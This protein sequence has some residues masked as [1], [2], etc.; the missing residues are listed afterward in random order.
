[1]THARLTPKEQEKVRVLTAVIARTI[2]N[3]H[4]AKQLGLSVRQVQRAKAR[5]RREGAESVVHKLKGNVGNHHIDPSVKTAALTLIKERY[6]DFKPTFA[7][8]KLEEKHAIVVSAETTRLWMMEAGLWKSRTQKQSSYHAWRS[9]KEHFGELEQFDG[10]YHQWFENRYCDQDGHPIEVCLLAAI[11]DATGI[12]T[13]ATFADNE[14]VV[15]VFTFWKAY[16]QERGKPL[17]IYLDRFSTY[18]INHKHAVDNNELMTQFQ[19]ATQQIGIALITAH[20]AEAKGRVERLFLTLQDRL[21][22]EMRL[23]SINTPEEGNIFVRDVFLPDFTARFAVAPVKKGNVHKPLLSTEKETM[24]HIFS[25]KESRRVNRDFTIQFHTNWYQLEEIQPLTVRSAD[26]VCVE[27][28]LDETIHILLKGKELS[29]F[30][31]PEKPKKLMQQPLIITTHRLQY[32]PPL[33]H[34]WRTRRG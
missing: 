9:R 30:L 26:I 8:E 13:K 14:G 29:Y 20:S 23:A 12:I 11:D 19:R 28:W 10:S 34:P 17:G 4:A 6:E 5:Y 32:R 2:T 33:N 21:V 27:T 1:M 18:K 3:G 31:L 7:T 15:A 25:Q 24:H 16:C 22:K